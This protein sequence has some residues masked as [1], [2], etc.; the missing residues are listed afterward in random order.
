M[1]N[2]CSLTVLILGVLSSL[3]MVIF[4]IN[5]L[6]VDYPL[7]I[8][9]DSS[10]QLN[11]SGILSTIEVGVG[12]AVLLL[13]TVTAVPYLGV[14]DIKNRAPIK[15]ATIYYAIMAL[16]SVIISIYRLSETGIIFDNGI[17]KRLEGDLVCPTVMFR[18]EM[19]IEKNEDCIFNA[20]AD[21]SSVWNKAGDPKID[22]S[23]REMYDKKSQQTVFDAYKAARPDV[24]I[25]MDEMTLYHDCW[26]WGCD[27]ICNDRHRINI[28]MAYASVGVSVVYIVLSILSGVQSEFDYKEVPPVD[29]PDEPET[30]FLVELPSIPPGTDQGSSSDNNGSVSSESIKSWNFNLRM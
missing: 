18:S 25:D 5:S 4:Q 29:I 12:S 7:N 30:R 21:S 9:T 8:F 28:V 19:T 3:G 22:W 6:A 24:D 17:C 2:G 16:T 14:I 10:V 11:W 15:F 23:D 20:F 27:E 13:C 1:L 26:Y